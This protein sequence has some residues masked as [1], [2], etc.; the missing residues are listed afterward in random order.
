[1]S[2]ETREIEHIDIPTAG[3]VSAIY[4]YWR[5]VRPGVLAAVLLSMFVAA[6]ATGE[7]M[8]PTAALIH[9]LAGTASVVAGAM[10]MN[11]RF[12]GQSDAQMARTAERPLP[13]ERLSSRQVTGFAVVCSVGGVVYLALAAAPAVVL[14]AV[15]SWILYVTIYT[16]LKQKTLLQTPLGAVAGAIPVLLGAATAEALL[17]PTAWAL[18]GV[19]FCWQFPHTMAIAWRYRRE[20]AASGVR[21]ATVVDP[22]GRLAG[23]LAVLGAACLLPVSL[24]PYVCSAAGW[25]Y[26]MAACV[27]GVAHLAAAAR[28]ARQR[29]DATARALWRVSL[30][31]LPLLLA[32]LAVDVLR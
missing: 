8:P 24:V 1:L 14:L 11:Q 7:E 22:S 25:T 13:A 29:N 3:Y 10:A 20:Y 4:Q 21:V 27:T 5:L 32:A 28:F 26:G 19:V 2:A 16:P 31:H 17:Q 9:A 30:I 6:V 23:R 15:L 18:F 12:E